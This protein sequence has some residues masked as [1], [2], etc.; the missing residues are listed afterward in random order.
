M[1]KV[2]VIFFVCLNFLEQCELPNC[3]GSN[4]RFV[5]DALQTFVEVFLDS[6]LLS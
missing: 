2:V 5:G 1:G 6:E 3:D 4:T